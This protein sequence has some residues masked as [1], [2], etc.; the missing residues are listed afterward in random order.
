ML[1]NG[2]ISYAPYNLKAL[3]K[4]PG[5]FVSWFFIFEKTVN[6][7][8]LFQKISAFHFKR[9]RILVSKPVLHRLSFKLIKNEIFYRKN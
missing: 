4:H 2:S 8:Y 5:L 6:P 1:N 3:D 9:F 7:A